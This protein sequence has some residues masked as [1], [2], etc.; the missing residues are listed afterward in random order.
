M[1]GRTLVFTGDGKGKT[2]AALGMVLRAAGHGQCVLVVQFVKG[3][4]NT[5]ELAAC[6][7]L[8][9]VRITQTGLGFIPAQTAPAFRQHREAAARGLKLAAEALA[10]EPLDLLVLDEVCLAVERG[11]LEEA[12]VLAVL[13]QRTRPVCLVLTG[14]GATPG[15]LAAADTITEMRSLGHGV[16]HGIPAQPGVEY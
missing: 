15:L 3:D 4:S 10:N 5:G 1:R 2:T 14:R 6:A 16:A 13:C 7:H 12:D 11:L 9:G 8:P